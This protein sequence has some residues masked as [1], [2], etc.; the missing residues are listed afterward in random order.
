MKTFPILAL[1]AFA[2]LATMSQ[3]AHAIEIGTRAHVA[4]I[5][6]DTNLEADASGGVMTRVDA[7]TTENLEENR[8]R[9]RLYDEAD[10]RFHAG[11]GNNVAADTSAGGDENAALRASIRNRDDGTRFETPSANATA[12]INANA[13]ANT[14]N[15][16]LFGIS[17][18][19]SGRTYIRN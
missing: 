3:Q 12:R 9:A 5:K 16:S 10:A 7:D 8:E 15:N 17:N 11:G 6:A 14:D 4:G 18:S 1:S 13:A 19:T 2:V